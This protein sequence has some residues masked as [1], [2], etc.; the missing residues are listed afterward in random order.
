[1]AE[2]ITTGILEDD[3]AA[4]AVLVRV[5]IQAHVSRTK[6][7]VDSLR[8]TGSGVFSLSVGTADIIRAIDIDQMDDGR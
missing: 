2:V 1:M 5:K 4:G 7:S 6:I 3:T 8:G